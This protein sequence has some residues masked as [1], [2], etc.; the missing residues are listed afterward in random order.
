MT[1][2]ELTLKT[3]DGAADAHAFRPDGDGPFP[4][5][6]FLI[7]ALGIRPAMVEMA[8]RLSRLGYFVLLPN[9][10]YRAGAFKP[11]DPKA[12]W[13]DPDER[14]RLMALVHGLDTPSAMRDLG[15]FLD[16]LGTQEGV[17]AGKVGLVGY[18][19]GGRLGLTAASAFPERVGAV[20]S[21]HGGGLVTDQPDSPHLGASKIKAQVYLGV[22]DE[23]QGCTP[24]HQAAL[25]QALASA[26]VHYQ[27]ELNPGAKHGYAVP[28]MPVY[29]PEAA[30]RHW[31]RL[32][33]VF[34][35]ALRQG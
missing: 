4:A 25:A 31:A 9:P 26:K 14:A 2:L 23:D 18:C 24:A 21:F 35:E 34:G 11:F 28:D 27:L 33:A 32:A 6:L 30:E 22:A 3:P 1:H 15:A 13:T 17:R 8:E 7:D 5:V 10:F 12:V 16:A 20:C 29:H 19:M